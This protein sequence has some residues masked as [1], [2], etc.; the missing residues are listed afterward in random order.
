MPRNGELLRKADLALADLA[1]GGLLNPEQGA[2]FVRKLID[3]PTLLGQ[4][5]VVEMLSPSRKIEKIG[6]GKRILRAATAQTALVTAAV[7]GVFDPVAEATARAKPVT[8]TVTLNT[9]EIIAEVRI[10]YDVMEDNIERAETANNEAMN[11]G[12]GGL[13]TTII[14]MIAERAA[15]DLEELGLLG[16]KSL[17]A[18]DPFLDLV[19]GFIINGETNGNLSDVGGASITKTVFKGGLKIMPNKYLRNRAVMRHF[20]SNNN[21]TEYRDTLA[22][23]ATAL[24]DAA[25]TT[26]LPLFAYGT[27][28]EKVDLMPESKGIFTNPF[29]LIYG[30][31]RDVSLEFDK[32]ITERVYIIVLTA[33]VDVQVEEA[34][35]LVIYNNIG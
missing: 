28:V 24:G 16:D 32:A 13:R 15:L 12:P 1:T 18:A 27:Q 4:A 14:D 29:N 31:Q 3:S 35:A 33:R 21:E 17:D 30:V 6:F 9:Q 5:R 8:E 22:D 25:V 2:A 23:R 11:Q 34:E 7:D 26:N 20:I 19:D 10:P